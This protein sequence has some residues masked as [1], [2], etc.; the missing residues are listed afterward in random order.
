MLRVYSVHSLYCPSCFRGSLE[1]IQNVNAPY[2]QHF[3]FGLYLASN[4][5]RQLAVACV[6][7]S[8]F[9]RASEGTGQSAARDSYDLIER[10]CVRLRNFRTGTIVL[11]DCAVQA[12]PYGFRFGR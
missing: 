7:L 10:C 2:Q 5:G 1:V 3:V 12:E 11:G 9:Q 8:R 4:I 6:Y